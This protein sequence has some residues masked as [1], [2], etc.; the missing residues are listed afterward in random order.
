MVKSFL[1]LFIFL[2]LFSAQQSKAQI[3]RLDLQKLREPIE[4]DTVN[5]GKTV[6][7]DGQWHISLK[8][9]E[10]V[11]PFVCKTQREKKK[12]DQLLVDV[13]K[14]YPLSLIVGSEYRLVNSELDSIYK[15]KSSRKKYIKWYQDYVYKK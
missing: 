10:I 1:I 4:K 3:N 5:L 2:F 11:R 12:Y 14:A 7:E 8:P 9:V 6:T 13:K 15:E